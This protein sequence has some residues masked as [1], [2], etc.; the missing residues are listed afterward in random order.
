[1]ENITNIMTVETKSLF[2]NFTLLFGI[3]ISKFVWTALRDKYI[4]NYFG[5][6]DHE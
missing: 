2:I 5:I 6:E 3:A 4:K 1:M